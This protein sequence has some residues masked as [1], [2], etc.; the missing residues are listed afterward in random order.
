MSEAKK[1]CVFLD[2]LDEQT[3]VR[4]SQ[5][6]Y[7]GDYVAAVPTSGP[8]KG[9][10]GAF[11]VDTVSSRGKREKPEV[12]CT[13]TCKEPMK[14]SCNC[15]SRSS[16]TALSA[17]QKLAWDSFRAKEYLDKAT[18]PGWQI[19]PNNDSQENYTEVLLCHAR[20]YVFADMYDIGP[21]RRLAL[22][23]LHHT[24]RAHKLRKEQLEGAVHLIDYTY[25]NTPDRLDFT[26]D[27]RQLVAHYA[28]VIIEILSH[29]DLFMTLLV[30]RGSFAKDLLEQV[31]KRLD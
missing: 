19:R 22:C 26:D 16:T 30:K 1:G 13:S 23:K 10:K 15:N 11:M 24:L 17:S 31:V 21:L 8:A 2:D 4:F 25:S 20:L 27:L 12:D 7:T 14:G 5:W 29:N 6:A 3:F 28:S 9:E 18:I